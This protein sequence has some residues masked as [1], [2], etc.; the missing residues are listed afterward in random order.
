MRRYRSLLL[1]CLGLAACRG[2]DGPA[3]QQRADAPQSLADL[4]LTYPYVAALGEVRV[5]SDISQASSDQH[6]QHMKRVWD[7]FS[8]IW[9][10]RRGDRLD[11]YYSEDRNKVLTAIDLCPTEVVRAET[12]LLTA[13]YSGEYPIWFIEPF[14]R[15]DF[16][17]QLHEIS[18]DF[19]FS[20]YWGAADFPWFIEG[21]GMYYEG[22]VFQADGSLTT[23]QPLP[24]LVETFDLYDGLGKLLA[25]DTLVWLDRDQFYRGDDPPAYYAQSGLLWYFLEA[26][27]PSVVDQLLGELNRADPWL[28]DNQWVLDFIVEATGLSLSQLDEGY[29]KLARSF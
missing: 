8:G 14:T 11:W 22:G 17:T 24:R 13:C 18:H 16:G 5:A 25:L 29:L 2:E 12:R 1:V 15:P 7:S 26:H 19:V 20:T 3:T 23:T 9:S 21:T 28:R 6:V 27:H 4:V 10:K